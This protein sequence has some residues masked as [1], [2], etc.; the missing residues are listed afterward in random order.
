MVKAADAKTESAVV[1]AAA[2]ESTASPR[3]DLWRLRSDLQFRWIGGATEVASYW[4]V[5]D[6]FAREW[7][8][9]NPVEKQMLDV[10]DGGHTVSELVALAT[11]MIKPLD[12]SVDAI[13]SF[14][15]QARRKGL[16]VAVGK[17][18]QLEHAAMGRP[19]GAAKNPAGR[20]LGKL[21][22]YRLPGI[23]PNRWFQFL[24][25]VRRF[26]TCKTLVAVLLMIG[27]PAIGIVISRFDT[28]VAEVSAAYSQRD[29]TWLL[30]ILVAVAIAKSIHELAHVVACRWVGAECRELG[31]M[32]LFGAPCLYCDVTDLWSVPGRMQ[33]V[34]VSAAGMLAELILAGLAMLW[35]SV[36]MDSI[37]HDLALVIALVCSVSTVLVNANP[38]LRYDGYFIMADWIGVPNLADVARQRLQ[39]TFRRLVWGSSSRS[40]A[41]QHVGRRLPGGVL[42]AY[43]IA[44]G[45]YRVVIV[46]MLSLLIYHGTVD[47][48]LG[49]LGAALGISLMVA[50]SLRG[51]S[52]ILSSPQGTTSKWWQ[53]PRPMAI[54]CALG[55]I[56]A[57]LLAIP[58]RSRVVA[59][60]FIVATQQHDLHASESGRIVELAESGTKVDAGDVLLRLESDDLQDRLLEAEA[61]HA[62]AEIL[63]QAWQTRRGAESA[64]SAALAV[65]QKR[66]QATKIDLEQAAKRVARLTITAP[67][68]GQFNLHHRDSALV[69]E[70]PLRPGQW[71]SVGTLLGTVGHIRDRSALALTPQNEVD[72]VQDGQSVLLRHGSFSHGQTS[73]TVLRGTVQQVDRTAW[74]TI[75]PELIAV[76]NHSN[77][78]PNSDEIYYLVRIDLQP[79]DAISMPLHSTAIAEIAVE[80]RSIW[81][82]FRR[83]FAAEYRGI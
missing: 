57:I 28:V 52:S 47:V 16:L 38:L 61:A 9:L 39:G 63:V 45:V 66:L 10:V 35:W 22:A 78:S 44:S 67:I 64:N 4:V 41:T 75:P 81:N 76:S 46:A 53:S 82:R 20:L 13:V 1:A 68:S 60:V 59:P 7:F 71:V 32:L 36:T 26:A 73:G 43:A 54:V 56:T 24:D 25:S 21:V 62:V 77:Q 51:A 79:T 49:W 69:F 6:P 74:Q 8:C 17:G 12:A 48:G 19:V 40:A 5:K 33:R 58:I 55:L 2:S 18:G 14:Y 27:I 23:N 83:L 80:S 34:F 31:V 11:E 30:A 15:V 37:A 42:L 3:V 29:A 50:M 72:R 70:R 65:A